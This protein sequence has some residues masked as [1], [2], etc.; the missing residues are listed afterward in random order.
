VRAFIY[1]AGRGLRL[2]PEYCVQPK[3]L[4]ELGGRTLL[5]WHARQLQKVGIEEVYVVVGYKAEEVSRE[6]ESLE[7]K[8]G[9]PIR[10]ILNPDYT[11]GSV[12]S[13]AVSLPQ[14]QAKSGPLLLMDGDVL[15]GK[16][17][18]PRLIG[19]TH[20]TVLLI[21]RDYSTADDDPVLVPVRGGRPFEFQKQWSGACD[22]VGE[23][24]GFFKIDPADLPSLVELT[25]RRTTGT[26]RKDSYDEVLRDM[27]VQGRFGYEDVTGM[28]WGEVDFPGDIE[29]AIQ[30]V[31]P[32]IDEP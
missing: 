11:E 16:D 5:E 1:A 20:R 18:L 17:M 22:F 3:I 13:L 4:L 8:Y 10:P 2:G 23:S 29:F 14:L 19:S 12:L 15:Y 7:A 25:R 32:F 26:G 27:V 21:D 9:L 28:H 24:I 6:M 30:K 31:L